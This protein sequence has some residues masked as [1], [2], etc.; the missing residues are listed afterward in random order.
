MVGS[1]AALWCVGS[2]QA[3]K[4]GRPLQQFPRNCFVAIARRNAW[5]MRDAERN[6]YTL[7]YASQ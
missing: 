4:G 2:S 3:G 7:V 5:T 1:S 6:G